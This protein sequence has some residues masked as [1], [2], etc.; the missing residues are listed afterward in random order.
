MAWTRPVNIAAI[1]AGSNAL[2][3]VIARAA[4]PSSCQELKSERVAL[5]L[6][7]DAFTQRQ[8]DAHTID[9]AADVFRRFKSRMNQYD[10]QRYRAVATSAARDARNRKL[11]VERIYRTSGIRLEVIDAPEEAR[12]TRTAVLAAVGTRMAPRLIAD[13]GGGSLQV[14]LLRDGALESI[15]SLSVGTVRLME[16]FAIRGALS[17]QQE[18]LV[19]QRAQT[20]F[21][22]FLP[23]GGAR[24]EPMV[25]CGGNAEALALL[26][27][28]KPFQGFPTL[29]VEQLGRML[30]RITR[31][32]VWERMKTFRVRQ[33][34]AEVM[35][36]AAIVFHELGRWGNVQRAVVPGVGV[37]EGVLQDVLRSLSG[38]EPEALRGS[39]LL[40][41]ARQFAVRLSYDARHCEAVCDFAA[42]LFDALRPWHGLGEEARCLLQIGA[43]LH[44]IGHSVHRESHHKIGEYLVR[45][46]NIPGLS[47]AQRQLVAC[48]VRYHSESAPSADHKLYA[49]LPA[50]K[51][52]EVRLL[53][54]LLRIADRLDSDHRQSVSGLKVRIR[55]GRMVLLLKMKRASE[56]ILWNVQHGGELLEEE[57]GL[58]LQARRVF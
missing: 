58:K 22:R 44:D 17:R 53:V 18:E 38:Q 5:R 41:A 9:R 55:R 33:D 34:R 47:Q 14:S 48:L 54:S 4:S 46:G 35:A 30:R 15:A 28:G 23:A 32:D 29:S 11:L 16:K 25:W 56:L 57:Y 8:F 6:G 49:S 3:L 24:L 2:R 27:P 20:F 43:L 31:K 1:D 10:V 52:R 12:L 7:H 42:A 45:N 13:L 40:S 51:Q 19:R 36:I 21:R 26:A 50:S 39:E 37:K